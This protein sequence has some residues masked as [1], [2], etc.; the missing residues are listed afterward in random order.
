M[1]II[2][3]VKMYINKNFLSLKSKLNEQLKQ[4]LSPGLEVVDDVIA[5][6]QTSNF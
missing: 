5:Y 6:Y 2:L 4:V 3:Q 1:S